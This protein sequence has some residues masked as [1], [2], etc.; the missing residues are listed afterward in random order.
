MKSTKS[1]SAYVET[2]KEERYTHYPDGDTDTVE[3]DVV[4]LN[5]KIDGE[6]IPDTDIMAF[7]LPDADYQRGYSM[8]YFLSCSCGCAGCAGYWD[9]IRIHVKKNTVKWSGRK[10]AGYT[11]GV[12][13][14]GEQVVW[15]DRKNYESV[16]NELL[17]LLKNNQDNLFRILG[18][19]AT[20]KEIL[21][22]INYWRSK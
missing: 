16:T 8:D 9:G 20:G 11:G 2:V 17:D 1:L 4:L 13:N 5:V 15:F 18:W 19:K 12:I 22:H 10:R 7:L 3:E 14:T 6:L 21:E